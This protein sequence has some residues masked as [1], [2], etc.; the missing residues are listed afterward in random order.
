MVETLSS[1]LTGPSV[2]LVGAAMFVL[3]GVLT[4]VTVQ[5]TGGPRQ[6]D[7]ATL[8]I[9]DAILQLSARKRLVNPAL[10]WMSDLAAKFNPAER[11]ALLEKRIAMA[12]MSVNWPME[13]VQLY[14]LV[15]GVLGLL[16]GSAVFFSM[17]SPVNITL[18]PA[19]AAAGWMGFDYV[20]DKK[21]KTRQQEIE[22]ALPDILDQLTIIVEAGLGFEAAFQRVIESNDTPLAHE[23]A[24]VLRSIRLGMPRSLALNQLL[25]RTDVVQLRM[26]VRALNQADRSGIPIGQVFRVQA[27]EAREKRRQRAEEKAMA[28]PVKL[29]FPLVVFIL[30]ALFIA[31]LGPAAVRIKGNGGLSGGGG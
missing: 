22:Y 23:F 18:G 11:V 5:D 7:A 29:L 19:V 27:D 2:L 1:L 30:P 15:F 14:K 13:R 26:F 9:H 17:S 16:A 31:I 3:A 4:Y 10:K 21:S 28:L 6:I 20:L 8:G 25:D 24:R 12:G